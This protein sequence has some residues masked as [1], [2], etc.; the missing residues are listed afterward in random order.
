MGIKDTGKRLAGV[1]VLRRQ[2]LAGNYSWTPI[3]TSST[4]RMML[5]AREQ[6]VLTERGIN[7]AGTTLAGNWI[8]VIYEFQINC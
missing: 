3:A 5:I 4:I 1:P 2:G 7:R 6:L 8:L